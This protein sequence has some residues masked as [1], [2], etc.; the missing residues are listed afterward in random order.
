MSKQGSI[1][2]EMSERKIFLRIIDVVVVLTALHLVGSIFNFD[3]F[4][5]NDQH[6]V[7]TFVLGFY[8]SFFCTVFE[9]YDLQRASRITSTLKGV[10]SGTGVISLVYLLTPYFTPTLPENRL[11]ILYFYL[12]MCIS[13]LIWRALYIKLF[14]SSRFNKNTIL[15][16]DAA[17][18]DAIT[19]ALL[20]ADPNYNILGYINTDLNLHIGH[21]DRLPVL[22]IEQAQEL[23]DANKIDEVVVASSNTADITTQLYTWLIDAVESGRS[24]REYTQVYEEMTDRVPVEFVGKDFYR[25]FPFARSNQNKLYQVYQRLFDLLFSVV[26]ITLCVVILPIVLI[27]NILANRGPLFY[28]QIRIGANR[29]KFAIV[30]FRTMVTNAESENGAQFAQKNDVRITKFGAFLRRSRL[31]EMPQFYNILK[32]DMSVIGPRPERPVFVEQLSQI[33]PFY[34]TRHVIKPGL[35]GWA[36]VKAKYGETNDDHLRKLQYDLFY[37]KKRSIFLDLRILVKT[38]STVLFFKGQ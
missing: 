10:I 1:Y 32:G 24:V 29:K 15:V 4:K 23:L 18:A 38:L 30:K 2:F 33:I 17:E 31:D 8:I 16:A 25:Y 28:K 3:Y 21:D 5:I 22:S 7:W 12:A 36:Q 11:Q 26:G 20:K 34:E 14:A 27:G 6:W 35:T 9:L 37:I 13:L 19:H